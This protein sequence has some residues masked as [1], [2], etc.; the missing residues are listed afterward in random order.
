MLVGLLLVVLV[1]LII[2][3]GQSIA[4]SINEVIET[5]PDLQPAEVVPVT[6][7]IRA[8]PTNPSASTPLVDPNETDELVDSPAVMPAT[9]G[10]NL[11]AN[12]SDLTAS[13]KTDL[14][15]FN[16]DHGTQYLRADNGQCF[17]KPAYPKVSAVDLLRR[18]G[19]GERHF[20]DTDLQA[21]DL[22]G[23]VLSGIDF[24]DAN[25]AAVNFRGA[26]LQGADLRYTNL[27][28]ADLTGANLRGADLQ[29]ASMQGADLTEAQL[30]DTNLRY[31]NLSCARYDSASWPAVALDQAITGCAEL[32]G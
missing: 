18:Y 17:Q 6:E 2:K 29:G 27:K 11:P 9:P 31:V 19:Q 4:Q 25:L 24:V 26:D 32:E 13:Q 5:A 8:R 16:C 22:S 12:W 28:Q 14:N 7:A 20:R 23:A 1:L 30:L 10:P 3:Q 21:V 15:P